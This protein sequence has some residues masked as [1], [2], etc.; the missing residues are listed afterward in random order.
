MNHALLR[1]IETAEAMKESQ[2]SVAA[3]LRT[4]VIDEMKKY[5]KAHYRKNLMGKIKEAA[6]VEA[7]FAASEAPWTK[8]MKRM[9]KA[10][11]RYYELSKKVRF[12]V[13]QARTAGAY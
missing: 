3:D 1:L 8:L 11:H 13:D 4:N 5:Q 9:I 7:G 6:D 10:K 2:A 12:S